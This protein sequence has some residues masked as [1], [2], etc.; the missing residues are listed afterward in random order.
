MLWNVTSH[1]TTVGPHVVAG[2]ALTG[3][4][5]VVVGRVLDPG[6]DARRPRLQSIVDRVD[7]LRVDKHIVGARKKPDMGPRGND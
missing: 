5:H 3:R 6:V 4:G 7:E 1:R 2:G